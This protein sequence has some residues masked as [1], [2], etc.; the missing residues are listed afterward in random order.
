MRLAH[1]RAAPAY[2]PELNPVEY[3]WANLKDLELANLVAV[4]GLS[5]GALGCCSVSLS[6]GWLA[7]AVLVGQL[8]GDAEPKGVE[9]THQLG[10]GAGG[11]NGRVLGAGGFKQGE[12]LKLLGVG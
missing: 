11:A 9:M 3:L 7:V 6:S 12:N 5:P 2:A 10:Q 4:S 1:R 8:H